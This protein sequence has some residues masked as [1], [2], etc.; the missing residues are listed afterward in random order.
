MYV[1]RLQL[2]L[3]CKCGEIAYQEQCVTQCKQFNSKLFFMPENNSVLSVLVSNVTTSFFINKQNN[4]TNIDPRVSQMVSD[5]TFAAARKQSLDT[6]FGC[7][8]LMHLKF[9]SMETYYFHCDGDSTILYVIQTLLRIIHYAWP[10][11]AIW[12]HW[13]YYLLW[14]QQFPTVL[15]DWA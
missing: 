1:S 15:L 13:L 7:P 12:V 3:D 9:S 6:T 4:W 11:M 10:G 14:I 2:D 8:F 5:W